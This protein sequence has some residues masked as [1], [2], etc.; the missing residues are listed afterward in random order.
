MFIKPLLSRLPVPESLLSSEDV[1]TKVW[2]LP[3][4]HSVTG[5]PEVHDTN[6]LVNQGHL[7][8]KTHVAQNHKT[9]GT[10][11]ILPSGTWNREAER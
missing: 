11:P 2:L 9:R 1:T 4:R 10:N 3:R 7:S 8:T 5:V 6:L